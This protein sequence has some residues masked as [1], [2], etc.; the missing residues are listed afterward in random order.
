MKYQVCRPLTP[1]EYEALRNDIAENG[2]LVPIEIDENGDVLDGHH[3]IQAW[4]EL[5]AEGKELPDYP[6]I[7]RA[8]LTEEQKRN[9]ARKFNVLRRHMGKDERE[10]M[11]VDMRK[12]GMSY[13]KIGEAVGVDPMTAH[14]VVK[15]AGVEIST[16]VTGADGKQYPAKQERKPLPP[17]AV[18]LTLTPPSASTFVS[19]KPAGEVV[20]SE[21][22]FAPAK[23]FSE[24]EAM[25]D[26]AE[27]DEDGYDWQDDEEEVIK[28]AR[29][30]TT[31]LVTSEKQQTDYLKTIQS[32][33]DKAPDVF[34]DIA[35][36][37]IK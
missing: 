12:D 19:P 26:E 34:D 14:K 24:L 18:T 29:M 21:M 11:M 32:A 2:V 16:P 27:G 8:G 6:R 7:I 13:R 3:R 25:A 30:M 4:Q 28:P 9:H 17:N 33:R 15:N 22:R 1:I 20:R 23:P 35:T 37:K 31:L 10:Q 5:K 36:G